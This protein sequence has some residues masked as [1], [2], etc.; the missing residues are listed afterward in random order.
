MLTASL[1]AFGWLYI[2]A[3]WTDAALRKQT[4]L[5]QARVIAGYLTVNNK[6]TVLLN[7]PPRLA[8]A[9]SSPESAY[10]YAVRDTDGQYLFDGGMAV[11]PSPDFANSHLKLYDYVPDGPGPSRVFGAA[12]RTKVGHRTLVIQ[13]E[14]QTHDPAYVRKAVVDEFVVDG[15]WLEIL[16]LFVLLGY[17]SGSSDLQSLR[18]NAFRF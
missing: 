5:D 17:V 10:R 16:F 14:Q 15:D 12:L 4:L 3:E 8:E 9:Y 13:V 11:A 18:S 6:N 1:C 7:L 2:K